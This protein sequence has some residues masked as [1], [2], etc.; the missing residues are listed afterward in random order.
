MMLVW[1]KI[2][3]EIGEAERSYLFLKF[4]NMFFAVRGNSFASSIMEK[5]KRSTKKK[6]QKS[7]GTRKKVNTD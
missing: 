7:K 2:T 1:K 6:V 5:Y 4:T 3:D